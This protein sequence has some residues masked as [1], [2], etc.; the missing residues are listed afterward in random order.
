MNAVTL[1]VLLSAVFATIACSAFAYA[2]GRRV[3]RRNTARAALRRGLKMSHDGSTIVDPNIEWI[4]TKP[5]RTDSKVLLLTIGDVQTSGNWYGEI[6]QHF[7]AWHPEPKRNKA[8]EHKLG[9]LESTRIQN[10]AQRAI[11]REHV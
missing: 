2:L 8:L 11:N 3:E 10:N 7:K 9:I 5:P 6:G 4:Y 1:W